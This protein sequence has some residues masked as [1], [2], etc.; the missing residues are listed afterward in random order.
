MFGQKDKNGQKEN[1][2]PE[3]FSDRIAQHRL[4]RF[5]RVVLII[6]LIAGI[7]A[8]FW[9]QQKQ[10]IYTG[11]VT[12]HTSKREVSS[13]ATSVV[14]GN[15]ILSYS[16]DGVNCCDTSG[17]TLWN[18]T[19]E[20]QNPIVALCNAT[21]AIG[22]Y[23][24]GK[25]Y[26]MNKEGALGE[27]TTNLP[28]R[29]LCVSDDGV[30]AAVLDDTNVTWIYLYSAKGTTLAYFKT[31]MSQSGYPASISISPNSRLV[32][33]SYLQA[34][35]GK[36]KSGV[37]FY[38]FGDVGQN[39]VDNYMSGYDY[40]D[41]VIPYVQF[42]NQE[43]AFAVADNRLMFFEG[44]QKPVSKAEK[45]LDKEVQSVYFNS[46]YVAL[47]TFDTSGKNKYMLSVYDTGGNLKLQ[48]GFD[49]EYK[50]LVLSDDN[51]Y[52]YSDSQCLIYNLYGVKKFSGALNQTISLLIP[53][54]S[55]NRMDIVSRSAITKLQ[56]K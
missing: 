5:L 26:V 21:A 25:I 44:A 40:V 8:V 31:T 17:K 53:G 15:D 39:E 35:S 51:I 38:N 18:E 37:A 46:K 49:L 52:I 24:G 6:G 13:N 7:G 27:I 19:Y 33:V 9:V 3:S 32:A 22:D 50:N 43:E 20:M 41:T 56:L 47:V 11:Y 42:M 48:K 12:V 4:R 23:N 28:I 30:V 10:R 16:K 34:D 2:R 55:I 1:M 45:L 36:V 14:L 29:A 54:S